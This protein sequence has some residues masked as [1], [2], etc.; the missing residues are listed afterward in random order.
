[1]SAVVEAPPLPRTVIRAT[2]GWMSLGLG[3]IWEY[4]ELLY[5]LVWRDVKVRYKQTALGAAWAIIQPF[6]MMLV[7]SLFF[8][9]LGGMPSDGIFASRPKNSEK[10]SIVK[11]GCMTA[12]AAP[13]AVCL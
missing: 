6:F 11:S 9:K 2:R 8:G 5:F 4:R 3:E 10:M 12:H 13:S 7:F 1:M